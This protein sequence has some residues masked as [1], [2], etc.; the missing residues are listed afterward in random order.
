MSVYSSAVNTL[1]NVLF[2]LVTTKAAK[3]ISLHSA[4]PGTT[5][6]S[7]IGGGSYARVATTW[8]S[9]A[10][11]AVTG[12]QV[13][14]NVPASTTIVYWGIW[15]AVSAGNYYDGG[16]LPSSQAYGSA[17]TYLLTPTLTAS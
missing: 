14:I 16:Q 15:D 4:T 1:N 5:G 8:G 7:E 3:Y 17:G 12:T 10:A 11:G 13:T 9:I 2:E 6:A